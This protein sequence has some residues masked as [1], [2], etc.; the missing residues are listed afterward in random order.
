MER[1][2][3]VAVLGLG[4]MGSAALYQLA[5]RGVDV[6]GIDRHRPPHTLGSTHGETRITRRAIGEGLAYVPLVSRSHEIWRELEAETGKTLL[7]AVGC[8]IISK[9]D[10]S[11]A[12]PGRTGFI[13]RT[14]EAAEKYGIAH[15]IL[16]AADIRARFPQ[17]NVSDDEI[18]YFEPGAG[19]VSP[20]GCVAAQLGL[21]EKR[22][23]QTRLDTNVS[24]I[25][26]EDD[27]VRLVTKAG[28]IRAKKLVVSAGAGAPV[29]LGAP[30]DA[31]LQ[32]TRQSMHWFEIAPDWAEQWTSGPVFI[33]PHGNSADDF[34]YGFPDASGVGAIKTADEFYGPST[35]P[36][37][38][39][40][41]VSPEQSRAM[42]DLHL[43]N[44]LNG[45]EPE[46]RNAVTCLYTSTP[47][48]AFL[49]DW[50]PD[51][52]RI[53]VVSP[54]SGHG[55]KHSAAIGEAVAQKMTTGS[56]TIDLSAFAFSRF[57]AQ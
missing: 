56:S 34:F 28:D 6:V 55:F 52:E 4:A 42:F 46:R 38:M 31:L 16:L 33:W 11:V 47:D 53:L 21:A 40:R 44:R 50:H 57:A 14:R 20:E 43:R 51:D 30:F 12:R 22:G 29:L 13:Q 37:T 7:S 39:E 17:F 24:A 1:V 36:Q 49:I 19:Y 45:I 2:F 10:D 35:D 41:T 3:E 15:E 32:V 8:L 18:G 27:H 5:L 48:S 9:A 54:C 25:V 23:A 26:R